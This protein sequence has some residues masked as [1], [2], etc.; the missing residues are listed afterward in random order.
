MGV[1]HF[2]AS[3]WLSELVASMNPSSSELADS[4]GVF[5]VAHSL[6]E[7]CF[8][9]ADHSERAALSHSYSGLDQM[10]REVMRV[11]ALFEEWSCRHV[12]FNE[13]DEVWPYYI[14]DSFGRAWLEIG[15]AYRLEA[16]NEDDCLRVAWSLNL[17]LRLD[18]GLQLP[19]DVVVANPNQLSPFRQFRIQTVRYHVLAEEIIPFVDVS[20]VF[21]DGGG[22]VICGLYGVFES[23]QL[24]NIADRES[25]ESAADLLR[26]IAPGVDLPLR[27][28]CRR[29]AKPA[30]SF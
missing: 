15:D 13:L 21:D 11:G 10:M 20:E 24:E 28:V 4:A 23:G 18:G 9:K 16:F 30:A 27:P 2:D 12:E 29:V 22:T 17:P 14:A 26:K 3:A 19:I 5:A 25:Y 8:E 6:W 7:E 1:A